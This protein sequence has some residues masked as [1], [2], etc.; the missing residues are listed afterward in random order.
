MPTTQDPTAATPDGLHEL[1]GEAFAAPRER[2]DLKRR[3]ELDL[4]LRNELRRLIPLVQAQIDRINHGTRA[5]YS[6]DKALYDAHDELK[7]GLSPSPLA[8][9][10]RLTA[11]ARSVRALDQFAGGES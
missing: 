6:R 1:L 2:P 9:C 7:Q 5:W 4:G 8:G 3:T 11:L 10:L